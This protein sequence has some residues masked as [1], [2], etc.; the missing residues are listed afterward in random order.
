MTLLIKNVKIIGSEEKFPERVDVFVLG[1][2]ISA[3]GNFQ[4][5]KADTVVDGQGAYLSPGFIDL[6][7]D[8]DHFL[9]LFDDPGQED[10]LKQGV[11]TI[12]GGMCGSSLAP[13]LYGGLESIQ[14]WAN[15]DRTN[16]NWHRVEEFFSVLTK[17]PLG[18]NFATLVG[19][20]TIRRSL[21]GESIRELTRNELAIFGETLG[22]ALR[23]GAMGLS[24]GLSY[25]HSKKTPYPEI[26]FLNQIV[27]NYNGLY[28]THLR[29][30]SEGISESVAETIKVAKETG[31]KTLITHFIP[32]AGSEKEYQKALETIES[33]PADWDFHF[34]IYPHHTTVRPLYTFLPLWAQNGGQEI[35]MRNVD[36]EWL[37]GR[38]M[39]DLPKIRPDDFIVA[40]VASDNSLAGKSLGE[41][42]KT[43]G[44]RDM[45]ETLMKLMLTT[46]LR[47]TILYKEVNYNLVKQAL[48]SKRALVASNAASFKGSD[49]RKMFKTKGS[50]NTFTAFLALVQSENLMPLET[51]IQK[52]TLEPAKKLNLQGRGLVKEGYFADLVGFKDQEVKFT[53]VN[54]SLAMKDGVFQG[55]FPGRILKHRV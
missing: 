24:T 3:I 27:K 25:V 35:M 14:K 41:V 51:A 29:N 28:A 33:L 20:S 15:T 48:K 13:L 32:I 5:K 34:D 22:R 45:R 39:K 42:A 8:S 50:L 16:V 18:V 10:F 38:I 44:L 7:T 11:T 4:N 9:S 53:V 43:F 55:W 17:K 49:P 1:D 31:V 47:A 2:K 19:H 6:N 12:L 54:G 52:I 36:E 40:N 46:G 26:K 37:R 30:V 21:V 23:E